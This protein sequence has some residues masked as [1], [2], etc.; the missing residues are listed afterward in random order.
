M[1]SLFARAIG[2]ADLQSE[3]ATAE[4]APAETV[5]AAVLRVTELYVL[6]G[7]H[8]TPA[9]LR[10]MI[11]LAGQVNDSVRDAVLDLADSAARAQNA[12][13]QLRAVQR[14]WSQ[15]R[16]APDVAPAAQAM[17]ARFAIAIDP[18]GAAATAADL[19]VA[20]RRMAALAFDRLPNAP[21]WPR[22]KLLL[23]AFGFDAALIAF[24]RGGD[25]VTLEEAASLLAECEGASVP[26]FRT[27]LIQL[28]EFL[29][30][31][32]GLVEPPQ[33]HDLRFPSPEAPVPHLA[34]TL[35]ALG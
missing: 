14:D 31:T 4:L 29:V 5:A 7:E 1:K 17:P 34:S 18:R 33:S 19:V 30:G 25:E 20:R 9:L 13:A 3:G 12:L 27:Q 10:E 15:A 32:L 11:E 21:V 26:I 16:A 35:D 23:Q 2:R 8:R 6:G 24:L 22:V 28:F